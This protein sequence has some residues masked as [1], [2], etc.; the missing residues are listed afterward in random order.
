MTLSVD[1]INTGNAINGYD[2]GC[3]FGILDTKK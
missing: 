3:C 2:S 1:V